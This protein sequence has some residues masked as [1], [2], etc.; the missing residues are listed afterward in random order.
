MAEI[1]EPAPEIEKV[2]S[3]VSSE[4]TSSQ[5]E[6]LLL[7]WEALERPFQKRDFEFWTTVIA[8]LAL[9]CLILFFVK[10]WFFIAALIAFVFFYYVFTTVE[11][12]KVKHKITNKGIF[13]AETPNRF[14]WTVLKSFWF[15]EKWGFPLLNVETWLNY[16]R[17]LHLVVKDQNREEL[18]KVL[19]KYLPKEE[20]ETKKNFLDK[21]SAWFLRNLP[22]ETNKKDNS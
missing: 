17:V 15:S 11:P 21:L 16:P 5:E 13:Y 8:I 14:D 12:R 6:K 10:E 9:V 18:E 2:T 1:Q 19:L 20:E 4:E 3:G 7:E 22:L